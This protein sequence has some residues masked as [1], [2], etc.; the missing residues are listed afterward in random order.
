MIIT[1]AAAA[2]AVVAMIEIFTS[3]I[4]TKVVPVIWFNF[5]IIIV[6]TN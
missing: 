5:T 3:D 1:T 6:V 2:V 4:D